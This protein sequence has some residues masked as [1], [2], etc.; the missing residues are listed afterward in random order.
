[1]TPLLQ[2][3]A[4]SALVPDVA[5]APGA[6]LRALDG[7]GDGDPLA[8][9]ERLR[10]RDPRVAALVEPTLG[11]TFA[12]T[13]ISASDKINVVPARAELQVDSRVPPGM[14]EDG[15]RA[16]VAAVLDGLEYE[17]SVNEQVI[18]NA[19]PLQS[20]LMDAI[21]DWV[22][23]RDPGARTI[24]AVLPAF[25]DSRWFRDAFPDCVA[26]GFFPQRQMS[27]FDTWPLV[28]GADE[29]IDV[30]DLGLAADFF[31]E[32]PQRLLA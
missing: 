8:A 11:V 26:Y 1:M 28:H 3:L 27:I 10:A 2:R 15:V 13:R 20:P 18:G 7:N 14:G 5:E 19:S 12:P 29:R 22:S 24:P 31:S 30:R 6:A 21:A 32:L 16:H 17:L 23:Q 9:L 25:T 4:D